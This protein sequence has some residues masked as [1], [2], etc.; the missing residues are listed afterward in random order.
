MKTVVITGATSG[1]G[2][3]VAKALAEM[4]IRVI[5]VGR[6]QQSCAQAKAAL[7]EAVPGADITYY[8]GDLS[9][10]R[11]VNALG[12]A[13]MA[14]LEKNDG[15]LD[16]LINNAGGVRNWYTTTPD[17]YELQFALKIG[18]ASCRERV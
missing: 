16:A 12:E 17:G 13:I 15:T 4:G 7:L 6:S 14:H 9:V 10:Q 5:G 18:R 2:Y 11:D 1:I 8:H 3:A